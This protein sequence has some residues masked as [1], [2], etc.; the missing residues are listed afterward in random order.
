MHKTEN[1]VRAFFSNRY[2]VLANYLRGSLYA[3]GSLPFEKRI[4]VVPDLK[5]KPFLFKYFASHPEL[6]IAAGIEVISLYEALSSLLEVRWPRIQEISL[7]LEQ[8]IFSW[9]SNQA[10][11]D[12]QML[13]ICQPLFAYFEQKDLARCRQHL[14]FFADRLAECL[15]RI[16]IYGGQA[17]EEWK[18]KEG[19]QQ[20]LWNE[21]FES[22]LSTFLQVQKTDQYP[23]HLFGFSFLPSSFLEFFKKMNAFFY[24]FSPTSFFIEDLCT[25]RE[26]VFLQKS[27]RKGKVH[28]RIQQEIESYLNQQNPLLASNSKSNRTFLSFFEHEQVWS[29]EGYEEPEGK[30][31]LGCIQKDIFFLYNRQESPTLMPQEFDPSFEVHAAVSKLREIEIL[32]EKILSVCSQDK[33][34]PL[35]LHEILV[36]APDIN[37]Y[38]PF[39]EMVFGQKNMPIDYTISDVKRLLKGPTLAA[40]LLLLELPAQR[41]SKQ[42]ILQLFT[43]EKFLQKWNILEEEANILRDWIRQMPVRFAV[44]AVQRKDFLEVEGEEGTWVLAF[45]ALIEDLV[46][47]PQSKTSSFFKKLSIAASETSLLSLFIRIL[48]SLKED[49]KVLDE[50]VEKPL[51]F[52]TTFLRELAQKYF[53]LEEEEEAVLLQ[54]EGFFKKLKDI[55]HEQFNFYSLQRILEK[56]VNQPSEHIQSSLKQGIKFASLTSGSALPHRMICL[57]GMHEGAFPRQEEHSSLLELKESDFRPS[58]MQEDRS[59]FLEVLLAAKDHMF[60]S[61]LS[62]DGKDQKSLKPCICVQE[63]FSYLDQA[64]FTY[65]GKKLSDILLMHHPHLPC[66]PFYF[67]PNSPFKS[68]FSKYFLGAKASQS[69]PHVRPSFFFPEEYKSEKSMEKELY[70]DLEKLQK[71]A[72]HPIRFF[73]NEVLGIYLQRDEENSEFVLSSLYKK[74]IGVELLTSSLSEVLESCKRANIFPPGLFKEAAIKML[75]KEGKDIETSFFKWEIKKD[76]FFSVELHPHCSTIEERQKGHWIFPPLNIHLSDG[77]SVFLTGKIPC[78]NSRGMIVKAKNQLKEILNIWPSL[79]VFQSLPLF[80][81][82]CTREAFFL[83]SEKKKTFSSNDPLGDLRL[84]LDYY[85]FCLNVPS[86]LEPKWANALLTGTYQDLAKAFKKSEKEDQDPYLDWLF[87]QEGCP[88]AKALFEKWSMKLKKIF[89]GCMPEEVHEEV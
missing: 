76:D 83:E 86:P 9:L 4:V 57:L 84:F 48:F 64:F 80:P 7:R 62:L 37:D 59:L 21:F 40:F 66:D 29:E 17:R 12:K 23:I 56:M 43:Y 3:P 32:R 52:W 26:K 33:T 69:I 72:K 11:L 75:E 2:E 22:S 31:L 34:N 88:D 35:Q 44:D 67:S 27:L 8:R 51:S 53:L 19:W 68:R 89:Q 46:F 81:A 77:V 18:R 38:I 14:S 70:L 60:I 10:I 39:I 20:L 85:L 6:E 65:E 55:H 5:F 45:D 25:D 82:S 87:K 36:L 47:S 41:F 30:T 63:L 58:K 73:L 71:F 61:Y 74:L 49:L 50:S 78:L 79:L 42:S 13:K 1:I 24:I 54:W 16:L 15:F 28:V